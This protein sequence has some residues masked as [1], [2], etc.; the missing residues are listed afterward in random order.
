[1]N[2]KF[3][4]DDDGIIYRFDLF[5]FARHTLGYT[6]LEEYPHQDWCRELDQRRPRSLWLEPR[7]TYKST[8]FTK[9]YPIWRLLEDPDLRILLVNATA[10]N[11]EAFL[12]EIV[13]HYLRNPRIRKVYR[14]LYHT[15][16]LDPRAA[17]T[18]SIILNTRTCNF[19]EPLIGTIGALGNLVSAHYD[20]IIVDDLCNIDDRESP[21]VREKKKRWFKDLVSVLSPDGELVIVG[22]HWHF[23][24]VYTYIK[25]ELNPQLP[26][27]ARYYINSESCY[28]DDDTTPRFP[29]ILP[30]EKL[31]TIKIEK[32]PLLFSC[33]YRNQPM[34]AEHQIFRLEALRT[35]PKSEIN[36]Q[37]AEAYGFCDPSLGVND[38]SAI[39]TVLKHNGKWVVFHADLS[40]TKQSELIDRIIELHKLFHYK[41]FGIE[42]NSIGKAKSDPNLSTFELVLRERQAEAETTVPYK[43]VWHTTQKQARIEALEPYISNGQLTFLQTWNQDYPLLIEQLVHFSLAAHDDGPDALAGVVQLVTQGHERAKVLVPRGR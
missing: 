22:T 39:V 21:T 16:P 20:L 35:I 29:N 37:N 7:Y 15:L 23:D 9:A 2:L 4:D 11:A 6:K 40:K 33:Q 38:Y 19:S 41:V 12:A 13:G 10:E 36:L 14:T 43:L 28:L 27:H 5:A 3:Y 31:N 30:A 25:N 1:M 34:P 8:V 24:D 42:A 26:Q 18:K 17:K 32:G